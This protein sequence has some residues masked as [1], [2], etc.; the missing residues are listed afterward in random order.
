MNMFYGSRIIQLMNM[1]NSK[2][3]EEK[4]TK[5]K[6]ITNLSLPYGTAG[7]LRFD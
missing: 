3:K 2:K 6:K 1:Q 5:K 4:I 7:Q